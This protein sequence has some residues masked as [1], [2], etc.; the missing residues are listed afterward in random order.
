MEFIRE[1]EVQRKEV[2]FSVAASKSYNLDW[3]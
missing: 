1:G 2:E 3:G